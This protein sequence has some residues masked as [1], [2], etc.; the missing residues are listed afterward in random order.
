[1]KQQNGGKNIFFLKENETKQNKTKQTCKG[2]MESK[3]QTN[4]QTNK[5]LLIIINGTMKHDVP[6]RKQAGF[7]ISGTRWETRIKIIMRLRNLYYPLWW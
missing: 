6:F 7:F 3:Q 2:T 5:L 4:T 1:M